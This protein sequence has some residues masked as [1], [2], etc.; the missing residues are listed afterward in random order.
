MKK[1]KSTKDQMFDYV[2]KHRYLPINMMWQKFGHSNNVNNIL[3]EFINHGVLKEA[4]QVIYKV[5]RFNS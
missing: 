5:Y 1:I 2:V 4:G 3:A